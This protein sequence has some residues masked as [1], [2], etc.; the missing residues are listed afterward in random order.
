MMMCTA[1]GGGS[2]ASNDQ[3]KEDPTA[4]APVE[5][6]EISEEPV[7]LHVAFFQGGFG[8]DWFD[9]L[10][11]AYEDEHPNVTI[12]LEGDANLIKE[13]LE[14]RVEGGTDVPDVIFANGDKWKKWGIQG[15][16]LDVSDVYSMK[17]NDKGET[18]N[19]VVQDAVKDYF[20]YDPVGQGVKMYAVPWSAGSFGV[21]INEKM[22]SENGW[23]YP[24]TWEGFIALCEEIKASGVAAPLTYP[25]IYK[26]YLSP[27][28]RGWQV[29]ELGLE[30]WHQYKYPETEE[31]YADPA[32]K[33]VWQKWSDLAQ[34]GFIL[35]GTPALNHTESQMEFIN[36]KAAMIL[37]GYWLENEMAEAWP[38]DYS[39]RMMPTPAG[40]VLNK[41]TLLTLIPD[42]GMVYGKTENPDVAKDFLLFTMTEK[43]TMKFAELSGGIRPLNYDI[44]K[45]TISEFAKSCITA[46]NGE[47][48]V[49]YTGAGS[50]LMYQKKNY[51]ELAAVENATMTV[52]D[53]FKKFIEDAQTHF[54]EKKDELGL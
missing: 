44:S 37:N 4:A 42:S 2:G 17:L 40:G 24:D 7:T 51:D 5:K 6:P 52:E 9:W 34:A 45:A 18:L 32:L 13:A 20:Y 22:F 47:N 19:D 46:G 23:E 3:P 11:E 16:A 35:E 25:G 15:L 36:G 54:A 8:R 29:Q 38:E 31:I 41:S 33:Q 27:F 21:V 26:N 12:E 48:V 28:Y 53:A 50:E 39:I 49:T 43:A 10:K 30:K 14:A 1:C